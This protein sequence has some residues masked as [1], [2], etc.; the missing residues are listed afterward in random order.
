MRAIFAQASDTGMYQNF[1][2]VCATPSGE[3][4][5][6]LLNIAAAGPA[7][8]T[9]FYV[10]VR[11]ITLRKMVERDL[12]QQKDELSK[13]AHTVAHD[14][15]NY[16]G[17]IRAYADLMQEEPFESP[18]PGRIRAITERMESFIQRQ[19]D[20]AEAGAA[21]GTS[22][23]FDVKDLIH[24]IQETI[25]VPIVCNTC[26]PIQG[27]RFRLEHLFINLIQNA[28]VHGKATSITV[29][30]VPVTDGYIITVSDNGCGINP[31]IQEHV[32]E[33][34]VSTGGTGFGLPIVRHIVNA[35]KGTITFESSADTGTTFTIFIPAAPAG[36]DCQ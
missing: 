14:L 22:S 26:C 4:R 3:T 15:K 18:I 27:D 33:M 10:I 6:L 21:I 35:H 32:F 12:L 29:Q 17:I 1:E 13:F 36:T 11:D 23:T 19:L 30:S 5:Y 7:E 16:V 2:F 20:L 8:D 31:S 9:S 34:G 25:N 24:G 28:V